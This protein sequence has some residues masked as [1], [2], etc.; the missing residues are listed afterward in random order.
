[1]LQIIMP[2]AVQCMNIEL[3]NDVDAVLAHL[4][5][6][7]HFQRETIDYKVDKIVPVFVDLLDASTLTAFWREFIALNLE[8]FKLVIET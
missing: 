7:T 2:S 4:R 1:M 6:A 8:L 3:V 5:K